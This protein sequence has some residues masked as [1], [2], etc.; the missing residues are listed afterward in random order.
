VR[1]KVLAGL[2]AVAAFA[3]LVA[4]VTARPAPAVRQIAATDDCP[5]GEK[6][7]SAFAPPN[8]VVSICPLGSAAC[9][10]GVRAES[11]LRTNIWKADPVAA[12]SRSAEP[13]HITLGLL[14]ERSVSLLARGAQRLPSGDFTACVRDGDA[15]WLELSG[16]PAPRH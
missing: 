6:R 2:L 11:I 1:T 15:G 7:L 3:P 12:L 14:D 16:T 8:G 4:I 5:S 13:L 9:A 10:D